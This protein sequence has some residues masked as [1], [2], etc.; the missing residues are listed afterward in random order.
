MSK[1]LDA[2]FW[3][4]RYIDGNTGWDIGYPST[5]IR[6]FIDTLEDTDLRILIP[7]CGNAYEAEYLFEQGFSNV[8]I[9][10]MAEQALLGFKQRFPGFPENNLI[11]QDFFKH[12]GEY[13]LIIEQTFFCALNPVLRSDYVRKMKSLLSTKGRLVGLM[14]KLDNMDGPPFGGDRGEYIN[15]FNSHFNSVRIDNCENSIEPRMGTEYWIEIKDP[16]PILL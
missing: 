6:Q 14:F 1:V 11:L 16:K 9:L 3:N 4:Q 10:D 2:D 5:P 12:A 8:H 7:G 15:L 13:D